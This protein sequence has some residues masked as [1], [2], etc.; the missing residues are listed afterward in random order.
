MHQN[1]H[2]DGDRVLLPCT[3]KSLI[4]LCCQKTGESLKSPV[5]PFTCLTVNR[6]RLKP[7]SVT[8]HLWECFH[9]SN[10]RAFKTGCTK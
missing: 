7:Q 8:S 6:F 3:G 4:E 9:Y 5:I 1:G 2:G 10:G